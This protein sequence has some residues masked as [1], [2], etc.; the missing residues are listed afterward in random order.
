MIYRINLIIEMIL[1]IACIH[2]LYGKKFTLNI[3]FIFLVVIDLILMQSVYDEY[4]PETCAFIIYPV[5]IGYCYL[6]FGND[7]KKIVV[8]VIL[9][10]IIICIIQ[11]LCVFIIDFIFGK[12]YPERVVILFSYILMAIVCAVIYRNIKLT[13]LSLYFQKPYVM[14]SALLGSG[15][16]IVIIGL[17]LTKKL[18]GMYDVEYIIIAIAVLVILIISVGWIKYKEKSDETEYKLRIYEMYQASYESL[19][20]EIRMRQHEF[21]NHL[22][23]IYNQHFLYKDY[24]S[25][26][27]HQR[28]YCETL[29]TENKFSKLLKI[30]ESAV[31]GFLYGKIMEAEKHGIEVEFEIFSDKILEGIPEYKVV[32]IIGNL[33]GNAID[34][35]M[36][37]EDKRIYF[38]IYKDEGYNVFA[39]ENTSSN[40]QQRE[41]IKFFNKGYSKK[42]NNRGIGLYS[43]KKMSKQFN[44]LIEFG[45]KNRI[46]LNWLYFKIKIKEQ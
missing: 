42:G 20:L 9:G 13:K 6:F 23:A 34:A 25:L 2:E 30:E 15:S 8:N 7:L 10:F 12:S 45:T 16:L 4:L 28:S 29:M 3:Y 26:V 33:F 41:I 44:F 17:F 24:K 18:Q 31:V 46:N 21:Q 35:V 14:V 11:V 43:I 5:I 27:E 32:E 1:L 37:L 38:K 22:N 40:I 36:E 19:I 39:I